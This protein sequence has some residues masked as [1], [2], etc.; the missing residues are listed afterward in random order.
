MKEEGKDGVLEMF[1]FFCFS[2]LKYNTEK[3][4]AKNKCESKITYYIGARNKILLALLT[5]FL[6]CLQKVLTTTRMMIDHF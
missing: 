2:F 3:K 6:K 4:L 1:S 5:P